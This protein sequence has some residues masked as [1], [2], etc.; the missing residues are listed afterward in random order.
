MMP[1]VGDSPIF[2]EALKSL[3]LQAAG[4]EAPPK[5]FVPLAAQAPNLFVN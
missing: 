1:A 5:N 3:V 2:I 4:V